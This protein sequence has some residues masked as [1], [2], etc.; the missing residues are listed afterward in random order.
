VVTIFGNVEL[1]P[2]AVIEGELVTLGGTVKRDP[3]AVVNR[4]QSIKALPISVDFGWFKTW[5]KECVFYGR[6]LAFHPD[7]MWAWGVALVSLLLYVL[8]AALVP[9]TVGKCVDT[10]EFGRAGRCWRRCC[11]LP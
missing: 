2:Q 11:R 9:H 6:L 8:T 5:V 7:L 10:L 1:G 4:V 3:A